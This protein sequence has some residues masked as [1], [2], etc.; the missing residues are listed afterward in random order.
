MTTRLKL[1]FIILF[2]TNSC[3]AAND[4]YLQLATFSNKN[5]A[6]AFSE[7]LTKL[8][9]HEVAVKTLQQQNKML[10]V[11]QI[12]SLAN[13]EAASS[14]AQQLKQQSIS[15]SIKHHKE[16]SSEP[17]ATALPIAAST[18]NTAIQLAENK[19]SPA[20]VIDAPINTAQSNSGDNDDDD[21][22]ADAPQ[23]MVTPEEAVVHQVNDEIKPGKS[24]LWNLRNADIRSVIAEVSRETGKNFLLDPRVQGKITIIANSPMTPREVYP[25]FLAALQISGY[26]AIPDD[27]ITKIIPNIESNGLNAPLLNGHIATGDEN[28][29]QVIP[30]RYVSAQQLVPIL[31]PLMPQW[32]QISA[33][34]PSNM[35]ILSGHASNLN[36]LAE[37]VSRVDVSS[38]DD[39]NII[40]LRNATAQDVIKTIKALQGSQGGGGPSYNV[41]A[42]ERSNAI[43]I[44]GNKEMRLR[45]R[46]LV[47]ELD[48]SMPEGGSDR[49]TQI[50]DLQYMQAKDMLPI[51]AGVAKS[52]YRGPVETI[53]GTRT[54]TNLESGDMGTASSTSNSFMGGPPVMP[55]MAAPDEANSTATTTTTRSNTAE[56]P[57]IE[58]IGEPN[59]NSIILNAPYDVMQI[60]KRIIRKIDVRPT[61]VSIEAMIAELTQDDI[62]RLGIRWGSQVDADGK[63]S[64]GNFRA[65]FGIITA[66]KV[67]DFEIQVEALANNNQSD[68]LSTPSVVVMDNHL[69]HIKV[70]KEVSVATTSYPNN[71]GG[72][73][74]A[75]PFTTFDRKDAALTLKVTPQVSNDGTIKLNIISENNTVAPRTEQNLA[76][77]SPTF[78]IS[79]ISTSV[80]VN[81]GDILVFGGLM[82]SE[83]RNEDESIPIIGEIP[84][85]GHLFHHTIRT[86]TKKKLMIFLHPMVLHNARDS[87]DFSVFKY[88]QQRRDQLKSLLV[89][90]Y[91]DEIHENVLPA[92]N[93]VMLP[94]PFSGERMVVSKDPALN[95]RNSQIK[96]RRYIK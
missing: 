49:D 94:V 77:D 76:N 89:Y 19:Q 10:Y 44:S 45:L 25:V 12:D 42:D 3:Y 48:T 56:Q 66:D 36:R 38:Y 4:Y 65:G 30:V 60:M 74:T 34:N 26:A 69:A 73:G 46:V 15:S 85:L 28:V 8:T 82:Q 2:L 91:N 95:S 16:D 78:N 68:V 37:I 27:H 70:G 61:Q 11:V 67:S 47:S 32:S 80:I 9:H 93:Q 17:A 20:P 62:N 87:Y 50:I 33:Y 63:L 58:I 72:Q 81:D 1:L 53:M 83:L 5:N 51:L 24:R 29:V 88:N 84:V 75:S 86:N 13:K 55:M 71:A 23:A 18:K 92:R 41:A 14:L 52:H 39:I 22:S 54:I 57:S 59:T 31:R 35:L 79:E 90:P 64:R 96:S 40:R 21:N 6:Q 43:V 7:Q